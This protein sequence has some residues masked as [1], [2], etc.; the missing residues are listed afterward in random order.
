MGTKALQSTDFDPAGSGADLRM[1]LKEQ[2][3][4]PATRAGRVQSVAMLELSSTDNFAVSRIS[5]PINIAQGAIVDINGVGFKIEQGSGDPGDPRKKPTVPVKINYG[6]SLSRDLLYFTF[7]FKTEMVHNYDM[8]HEGA[9]IQWDATSRDVKF[10]ETATETTH[11]HIRLGAE[12][13]DGTLLDQAVTII[14]KYKQAQDTGTK[15][16][17]FTNTGDSQHPLMWLDLPDDL[18]D[19]E[20]N[21]GK[22]VT[23]TLTP[24]D[25]QQWKTY[26][27]TRG[28]DVE[29]DVSVFV[30]GVFKARVANATPRRYSNEP[31]W[32]GGFNAISG[33]D[34]LWS[35]F[36]GELEYFAVWKRKLTTAEIAEFTDKPY[37]IFEDKAHVDKPRAYQAIDESEEF[38]KNIL[39]YTCSWVDDIVNHR[40]IYPSIDRLTID[41]DSDNLIFDSD[42]NN[43]QMV[44]FGGAVAL[45]DER[46]TV[47]MRM[48]LHANA[49]SK[50]LL[51]ALWDFPSSGSL[52]VEGAI[53]GAKSYGYNLV[54]KIGGESVSAKADWSSLAEFH[55]WS[56]TYDSNDRIAIYRDDTLIA[57]KSIS[58]TRVEVTGGIR[59]GHNEGTVRR[60]IPAEVEYI[61]VWNEAFGAAKLHNFLQFPYAHLKNGVLQDKKPLG[62]GI[63][64]S[65]Q[66]ITRGLSTYV[67]DAE[68]EVI[69]DRGLTIEGEAYVLPNT[70][71]TR[72]RTVFDVQIATQAP[73]GRYETHACVRGYRSSTDPLEPNVDNRT[74]TFRAR[75]LPKPSG[76]PSDVVPHQ[77]TLFCCSDSTTN[78]QQRWHA[79]YYGN[80][81][82]NPKIVFEYGDMYLM[83]PFPLSD[84]LNFHDFAFRVDQDGNNRRLTIWIDGEMVDTKTSANTYDVRDL[85]FRLGGYKDHPT[86]ASVPYI[87][88]KGVV[89]SYGIW[90]RALNEAEIKKLHREPYTPVSPNHNVKPNPEVMDLSI[91]PMDLTR[92]M[93]F[94]TLDFKKEL[95]HQYDMPKEGDAIEFLGAPTFNVRFKS[96]TDGNRIY[97]STLDFAKF[98]PLSTDSLTLVYKSKSST[99]GSPHGNYYCIVGGGNSYR[100]SSHCAWVGSDGKY[101]WPIDIGEFTNTRLDAHFGNTGT[102]TPA[103]PTMAVRLE[104]T[105]TNV[106]TRTAFVDGQEILKNETDKPGRYE[107][108]DWLVIGGWSNSSGYAGAK[109]EMEFFAIWNRALTDEELAYIYANPYAIIQGTPKA[110][111]D[112]TITVIDPEEE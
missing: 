79:Y 4:P 11:N 98:N 37:S 12:I 85:E 93:R 44:D 50:T 13:D 33:S 27:V 106:Y 14:F 83:Y 57:S 112:P 28:D 32:I 101:R 49:L 2:R 16:T 1:M 54:F 26:A 64:A 34:V 95:V 61:A 53:Q 30:D 18:G 55:T 47:S 88:F 56:F 43:I 66:T 22:W 19:I 29:D 78:L 102:V 31:F 51:H 40:P 21:A 74:A 48:R 111:I 92:D 71:F 69:R 46:F 59:V 65:D 39:Y 58:A 45:S 84:A 15:G 35:S 103:W 87:R 77:S 7:D 52:N 67:F 76:A 25:L 70:E 110:L 62:R 73:L 6:K 75:L 72:R 109:M 20:F 99:L 24:A 81:A 86:A 96:N 5:N 105:G 60:A 108:D 36:V 9:G 38:S 82:S 17:V 68:N 23:T 94:Y 41:P 91:K 80:V 97:L 42:Y 3:M 107:G 10:V 89:D 100:L 104:K 8:P 90:D 63:L